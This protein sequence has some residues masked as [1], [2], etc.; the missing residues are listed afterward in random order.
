M[1]GVSTPSCLTPSRHTRPRVVLSNCTRLAQ[2]YSCCRHSDVRTTLFDYI[3]D[4][5]SSTN[6][7]VCL[8]ILDIFSS[9]NYSV[10]ILDIFSCT[11]ELTTSLTSSVV[12][13]FVVTTRDSWTYIYAQVLVRNRAARKGRPQVD[14]A[15][16]AK[17]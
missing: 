4:V 16:S 6:S 3:L 12:Q 1:L 10:Y 8:H 7:P 13:D 14:S 9:T 2:T 11:P 17:S 5:F 15:P